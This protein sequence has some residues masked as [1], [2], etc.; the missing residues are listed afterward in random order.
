MYI[1]II[2]TFILIFILFGTTLIKIFTS[3]SSNTSQKGNIWFVSLLIINIFIIF[4]LY[5]YN[6]YITN[7]A[8]KEGNIGPAGSVGNKGLDC[9]IKDPNTMYYITYNNRPAFT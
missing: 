9:I 8:G 5:G 7:L 3:Y 1:I 2:T 6:Y 4:F